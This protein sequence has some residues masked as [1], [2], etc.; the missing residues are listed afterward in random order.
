MPVRRE[1]M[2]SLIERWPDQADRV[3]RESLLDVHGS[4]RQIARYFLDKRGS[5]DQNDFAA[6]YRNALAEAQR[7]DD[8]SRCRSAIGGLAETGHAA[9]A[10]LIAPTLTDWRASVRRAALRAISTLDFNQYQDAVEQALRDPAPSV[11]RLAGNLLVENMAE[12]AR[13]SFNTCA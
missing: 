8:G 7:H 4:I 12:S 3:L 13:E 6:I 5:A 9:D 11:S 10:A 1:A 2:L